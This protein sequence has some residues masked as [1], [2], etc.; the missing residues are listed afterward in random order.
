MNIKNCNL[1]IANYIL[2]SDVT[3][4]YHLKSHFS[5]PEIKEINLKLFIDEV[6]SASHYATANDKDSSLKIKSLMLVYMILSSFPSITAKKKKTGKKKN[7]FL[8]DDEEYI[9]D[10]RITGKNYINSF[11]SYLSFETKFINENLNKNELNNIQIQAKNVI[12][13]NTRVPVTKFINVNEF[14]NAYSND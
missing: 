4:K 11:L 3:Y 6:I 8:L 1:S 9:Y 12:N 14:F 2:S 13:F 7:S 5:Q 10:L